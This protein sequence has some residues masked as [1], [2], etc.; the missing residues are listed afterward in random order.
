MVQRLA[1]S[2]QYGNVE[3]L[4]C[5]MYQ[6]YNDALPAWIF[7]WRKSDAS[8]CTQTLHWKWICWLGYLGCRFSTVSR[9]CR[10]A[11]SGSFTWQLSVA[12]D[13]GSLQHLWG[14]KYIYIE[15]VSTSQTIWRHVKI[16]HEDIGRQGC[17]ATPPSVLPAPPSW[18]AEAVDYP[19]RSHGDLAVKKCFNPVLQWSLGKSYAHSKIKGIKWIDEAHVWQF[20]SF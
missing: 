17:H 15:S 10:L 14:W 18:N 16:A 1:A 9:K 20:K 13:N 11:S 12:K 2:P 5:Q 19:N 3:K 7:L 6:S 8:Y 4:P